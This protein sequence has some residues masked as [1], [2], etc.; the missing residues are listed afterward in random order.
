MR[1]LGLPRPLKESPLRK[2]T[3][4]A[5]VCT[6]LAL[7][8]ASLTVTISAQAAPRADRPV[9]AAERVEKPGTVKPVKPPK[10]AGG[11]GK[12]KPT[13]PPFEAPTSVEY[14]RSDCQ[15]VDEAS[16]RVVHHWLVS[17]G[18]YRYSRNGVGKPVNVYHGE[19]QSITRKVTVSDAAWVP[20]DGPLPAP[21]EAL[22]AGTLTVSPIGKPS[23]WQQVALPEQL[24]ALDCAE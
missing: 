9:S 3:Q 12:G 6:G 10:D 8:A 23:Q 20:E 1:Q 24:V 18:V 4:I 5:T 2:H 14:V 22:A 17:G 16:F 13:Y 7:V 11:K 21:T 19:P 15:R